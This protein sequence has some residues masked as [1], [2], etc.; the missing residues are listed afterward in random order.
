MDTNCLNVTIQLNVNSIE[1]PRGWAG[2]NDMHP[3]WA[4]SV[5][6]AVVVF[7]STVLGAP[8]ACSQ[9]YAATTMNMQSS[10]KRNK[11]NWMANK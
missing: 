3:S 1:G 4:S 2:R 11:A 8:S 7:V 9:R 6:V 10:P 5:V